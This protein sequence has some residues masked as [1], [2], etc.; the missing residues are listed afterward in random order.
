MS[1]FLGRLGSRSKH[2]EVGGGRRNGHVREVNGLFDDGGREPD[3][4]DL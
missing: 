1:G 4:V 3:T 2:L